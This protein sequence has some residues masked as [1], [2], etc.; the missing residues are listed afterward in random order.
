LRFVILQKNQHT[1]RPFRSLKRTDMFFIL[2]NWFQN[3]H[4][5]WR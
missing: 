2:V 4:I 3:R 1:S 5:I